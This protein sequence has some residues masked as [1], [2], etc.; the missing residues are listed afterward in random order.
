MESEFPEL[1]FLSCFLS[2]FIYLKNI[3]LQ[4]LECCNFIV[5]CD[6]CTRLKAE[7]TK[8]K[9]GGDV[10]LLLEKETAKRDHLEIQKAHRSY[11]S[12]LRGIASTNLKVQVINVDHMAKKILIKPQNYSKSTFKECSAVKILP[13]GHYV[14]KNDECHYFL[15]TE[16]FGETKDT[17][18]SQMH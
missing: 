12:A 1:R 16:R 8:A 11:E 7:I 9:V 10:Q 2:H 17:I 5:S 15:T 14:S 4:S 13:G 18:M 3:Y 6:T